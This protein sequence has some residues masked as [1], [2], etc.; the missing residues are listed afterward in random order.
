MLPAMLQDVL[1]RIESRLKVVGLSAVAAS[2]KAGLSEDAI[3]NMQRAARS[4]ERKTV[5]VRTIA[6]LAPVLKTTAAWLIDGIGDEG[7]DQLV[8][9]IGRVGANP[10]DQVIMTT[11]Q[12]SYDYV[13]LPPGGTSDSVALEVHGHS[14]RGFADDGS[15]I[16]F[17]IQRTP[18]GSDMLGAIVIV[19]TLDG[20]V[21]LKRL[22]RGSEKGLFDL[23]SANGP[24]LHDVRLA[25][26]AEPTAIIPPKQARKIIRRG[27]EEAA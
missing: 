22:L 9:I 16:Y 6:A 4:D 23:E 10:D 25:W 24:T 12:E 8:R 2:K 1:T 7:G 3:R 15:L 19:E 21:L 13:P 17:E 11:A 20:R 18:P 14:M 27:G 26:A 5:S